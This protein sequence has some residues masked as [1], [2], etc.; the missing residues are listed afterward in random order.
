MFLGLLSGWKWNLRPS[1]RSRTLLTRFSWTISLYFAPFIFS[2]TQNSLPV[3]AAEKQPHSL[4]LPPPCLTAGMVSCRWWLTPGFLETWC[5]ELRLNSSIFATSDKRCCFSKSESPLRSLLQTPR[6]ASDWLFC[7]KIQTSGVL[8]WWFSFWKFLPSPHRI[9][10]AQPEWP[11]GS[12]S[13]LLSRPLS[14]N[15][16]V[17]LAALGRVLVVLNFSHLRISSAVPVQNVLVI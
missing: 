8:L 15:Y 4:T 5:L 12:W 10:G 7:H 1:L 6:E 3:P 17:W 16:S 11:S 13:T 9:F 14:T 2:L